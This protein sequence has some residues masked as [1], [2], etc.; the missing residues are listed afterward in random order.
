VPIA[1]V[2]R[3][4]WITFVV[5]QGRRIVLPMTR[6]TVLRTT[7]LALGLLAM[8]GHASPVM[9]ND[10]DEFRG[11]NLPLDPLLSGSLN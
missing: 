9:A 10:D 2:N 7:R 6:A 1:F 3:F 5:I 11:P 8:F 4:D